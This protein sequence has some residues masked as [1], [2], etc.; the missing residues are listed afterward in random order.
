MLGSLIKEGELE[1]NKHRLR[2]R[3]RLKKKKK[4]VGR[5]ASQGKGPNQGSMGT[6]SHR[7][8]ERDF[9]AFGQLTGS[10]QKAWA[11]QPASPHVPANAFHICSAHLAPVH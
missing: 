9:P 5:N 6:F 2:S 10:H 8:P 3:R 4:G 7:A 11:G 1:R